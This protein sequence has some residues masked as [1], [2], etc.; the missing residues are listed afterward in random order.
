MKK[1]V[2]ALLLVA[3]MTTSAYALNIIDWILYKKVLLDANKMYILANR[4]TGEVKFILLHNGQWV[5][6][7]GV[8]KNQIQAMYDFQRTSKKK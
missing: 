5:P 7:E 1:I 3:L 2:I 8:W 6:L 4:I